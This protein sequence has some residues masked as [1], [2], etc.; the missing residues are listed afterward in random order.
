[1]RDEFP[2]LAKSLEQTRTWQRIYHLYDD[3]AMRNLAILLIRLITTTGKLMDPGGARA[4]VA[5]LLLVKHQLITLNRGRE[6]AP[7]LSPMD[8]VVAS[9]GTL[10][11][12]PCRLLRAGIVPKPSAVIAFHAELAVREGT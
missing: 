5:E 11:I 6:R 3:V 4:I 10:F 12:R 2:F 9:A 7:N 1:M 8:R